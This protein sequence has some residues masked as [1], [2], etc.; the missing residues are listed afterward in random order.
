M[1]AIAIVVL[2]VVPLLLGTPWFT[3]LLLGVTLQAAREFAR[4]LSFRYDHPV[5]SWVIAGPAAIL[6]LVSAFRPQLGLLLPTATLCVFL[7]LILQMRVPDV[8]RGLAIGVFTSFAALYIALPLAA[9]ALLRTLE[10]PTDAGWL[11]QLAMLMGTD[12]TARGLSWIA[13]TVAVTWLTD[14]AAYLAGSRLGKSKLAPRL[15][16]GKTR[17]GALAGLVIGGLIGGLGA[18][19]FGIPLSPGN[20]AVAGIVIAL[21]AQL[22]DLT[23]SFLK[24][25]FGLKDFGTLIP[26]HGGML[27]RIDALLATIPMTLLLATLLDKGWR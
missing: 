10:G 1:S 3:L 24:R 12:R 6:L 25:G 22:G 11:T 20:A 23:E 9:A 4:A 14:T 27:D 5:H 21:I 17:E 15:S 18:W 7:P 26:G 2:T 19:I 16:P 13:W 8:Q